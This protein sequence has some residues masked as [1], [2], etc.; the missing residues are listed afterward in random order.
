MLLGKACLCE[1]SNPI[2]QTQMLGSLDKGMIRGLSLRFEIPRLPGT[3]GANPSRADSALQ[4]SDEDKVSSMQKCDLGVSTGQD[5]TRAEI[6]M[7]VPT[8]QKG[9]RDVVEA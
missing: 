7:M 3:T 2:L 8:A 5:P 9:I 1:I 4:P 6:T